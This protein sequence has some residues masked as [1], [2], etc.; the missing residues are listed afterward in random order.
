LENSHSILANLLNRLDR[1]LPQ[2]GLGE[3]TD[4]SM[5]AS[6]R[7]HPKPSFLLL[8]LSWL[9]DVRDLLILT[10]GFKLLLGQASF[11]SSDCSSGVA[12]SV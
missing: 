10:E 2:H 8:P 4:Q 7:N 6:V 5:F 3:K 11:F 9:E 12:M 1:I